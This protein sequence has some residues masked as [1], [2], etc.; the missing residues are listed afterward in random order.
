MTKTLLSLKDQMI[1]GLRQSLKTWP[2]NKTLTSKYLSITVVSIRK[3]DVHHL[4]LD[5]DRS[6]FVI[7]DLS[8]A[9]K[10]RK[11]DNDIVFL[12]VSLHLQIVGY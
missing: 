5:A 1:R 6:I 8:K 11:N 12:E 7:Q 2:G 9:L 3:K 4:K 10:K